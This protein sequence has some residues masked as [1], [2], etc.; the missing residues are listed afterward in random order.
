MVR[1]ADDEHGHGDDQQHGED[2][3]H[4]AAPGA[5]LLRSPAV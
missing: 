3:L 4:G 5:T 1:G 2:V